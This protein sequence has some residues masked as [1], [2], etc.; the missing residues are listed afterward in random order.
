MNIIFI[1]A[2]IAIATC[3]LL[4]LT[5][6][7]FE[8]SLATKSPLLVK[9][10]APWCGHCKKL[11]PVWDELAEEMDGSV[12]IAKINCDEEAHRDICGQHGIRGYPTLKFLDQG[13]SIAYEGP[14]DKASIQDWAMKMTLPATQEATLETIQASTAPIY[15]VLTD[16]EL[17]EEYQTAA[18]PFKGGDLAFYICATE[19]CVAAFGKGVYAKQEDETHL[20]TEELSTF[21]LSHSSPILPELTGANFAKLSDPNRPLAILFAEAGLPIVDEYRTVSKKMGSA[22][23]VQAW[24]STTAYEA[25]AK[26]FEAVEGSMVVLSNAQRMWWVTTYE[27]DME[28]WLQGVQDGSI[29]GTP[30]PEQK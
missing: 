15:F 29:V 12:T 26:N 5:E 22:N 23:F 10:Y 3:E 27:G 19:E 28:A 9:F 14:R 7:N 11:A 16:S 2:C 24:I 8:S 21:V 30:F 1:I 6:D 13:A 17:T 4:V 18:A 25:F 20:A